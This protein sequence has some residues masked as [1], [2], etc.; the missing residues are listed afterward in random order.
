MHMRKLYISI[1]AIAVVGLNIISCKKD[2]P[3][4]EEADFLVYGSIYTVDDAAPQADA[5][6]VK[7]GKFVYVG[8]VDGAKAY[9][10]TRTIVIDH[11]DKGMVTPAFTDAHAHYLMSCG[12]T[13]MGSLKFDM[14]T[15][16]LELLEQVDKAY[17][18]AKK[19]GTPALYGFGWT[20]Q[21]FELLGMPTLEA[22]DAVC[23][24]IPLYLADGEGHKGLANSACMLKAGII[25]KNGE[26]I[27][28][29][30]RGG[31]ICVD[32][33]GYPTGLFK[34][35]AGTYCRLRGIDFLKL[36]D[37]AKAT[38]TLTLTRD[39][40]HSKGYVSYIDGWSNYFG[41]LR[42]YE[43]AKALDKAGELNLCLGLAYEVES[44]TKDRPA[45]FKKAYATDAY[46]TRHINPHYIKLFVDGTVETHTGY[47][48]EPYIDEE[49]GVSEPNWTPEEFAAITADVNAHDYTMHIHA[50]GDEGVH[51]AVTAFANKGRKEKRNTLVHVRNVLAEDYPVMAANNIVATSGV[52]WHIAGDGVKDVLRETLPETYVNQFY[53]IKSYFDNGV[54]MSAHS[55]FPALSG[56]S[57]LPLHMIEICVTGILPESGSEPLWAEELV[58]RQQALKALTLNGAYQM[59]NEKERG[60]IQVGKYADF[61][62]FDKDVMDEKTCPASDIHTG[63]VVSTYF[64][65]RK[66]FPNLKDKQL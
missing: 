58:T 48:R 26:L 49:G 65:G 62:I 15:T 44:S 11:R 30:I 3:S 64:E 12:M 36:I 43:A 21:L 2:K 24:D 19:D 38:K 32:D 18:Q 51:L 45:E 10:G 37:A 8:S 5:F 54:V 1:L 23:P 53:P 22:L 14:F 56:S 42:F 41:N 55:D 35:Q 39:A 7:D 61:V 16:P 66:V 27:I 31:E 4:S 20:Y 60:S 50:M 52:L 59:H 47:V 13:A 40:L 33:Y 29:E 9:K 6:A 34:E 63:K 28:P 46:A 57:E 25:N 17:R